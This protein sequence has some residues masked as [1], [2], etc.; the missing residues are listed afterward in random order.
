MKNLYI[1]LISDEDV[2][3]QLYD[4]DDGVKIIAWPDG[5]LRGR[6]RESTE[7]K[8]MEIEWSGYNGDGSG[9]GHEYINDL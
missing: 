1:E 4:K 9:K 5:I 3:I 8:G 7:Y 2:D 6:D